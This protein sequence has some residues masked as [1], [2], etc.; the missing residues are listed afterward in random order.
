LLLVPQTSVP[1]A[2]RAEITR[3]APTRIVV[4]GGTGAV[5][6]AAF[7]ELSTLAATV[8]R[9]SGPN[10]YSVAAAVSSAFF[11][12]GATAYIA[13]GTDFPDAL[14]AGP[15]SA[16]SPG[17]VLLV[18]STAIPATIAAELYRLQPHQ[19]VI[20][21]GLAAVSLSVEEALTPYNQ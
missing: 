9:I 2:V 1:A 6:A 3:L 18:Q 21:G 8:E 17:P 12:P 19:I 16:A 4:V 10:R 14:A 13:V 15:A 5:S 20:L 7:A 11:A